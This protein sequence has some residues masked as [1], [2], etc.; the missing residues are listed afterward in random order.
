MG[1]SACGLDELVTL[2][3][4]ASAVSAGANMDGVFEIVT[5][6]TGDIGRVRKFVK[7][8]RLFSNSFSWGVIA[9][10]EHSAGN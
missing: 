7:S 10:N 2:I 9:A 1:P 3:V 6:T 4:K 8:N 5:V